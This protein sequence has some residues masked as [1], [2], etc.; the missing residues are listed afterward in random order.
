[1]KRLLVLALFG[2]FP[3]PLLFLGAVLAVASEHDPLLLAPTSADVAALLEHPHV[4]LSVN[5]RADLEAGIVDERIVS[6]LVWMAE[7]HTITV[8]VFKTGHHKYVRGSERVSNHYYGRAADIGIVDGMAVSR[9]NASARTIVL[10]LTGIESLLRPPE[11]GHPFGDISFPGGFTD[12]DHLGH[13]HIGY[14]H[15]GG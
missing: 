5:A 7:R 8:G 9:S 2:V 4:S 6:L 15:E 10:D 14:E 12:D 11:V 1:M 3:F 13:I